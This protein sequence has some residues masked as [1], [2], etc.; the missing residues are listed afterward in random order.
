MPVLVLG[1][2]GEGRRALH[3]GEVVVARHR[4]QVERLIEVADL[5]VRERLQRRGA[6]VA[7]PDLHV[8]G[9]A[10]R[11]RPV[12]L[13]GEVEFQL[14]EHVVINRA[15]QLDA[16]AAQLVAVGLV[17]Q[18]AGH[19]RRLV[20]LDVGAGVEPLGIVLE[21]AADVKR[22]R[23]VGRL[24]LQAVAPVDA[25]V[26]RP[27]RPR[28]ALDRLAQRVVL[29]GLLVLKLRHPLLQR[30]QFRFGVVIRAR[31]RARQRQARHERCDPQRHSR[32]HNAFLH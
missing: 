12:V 28:D 26:R 30:V 11:A 22:E 7:A 24:E 17:P 15:V 2:K 8:V 29:G 20:L 1:R 19:G 23:L 13:V 18:R 31:R 5:H 21:P 9:R 25:E 14:V 16:H 32:S 27:G 3:E 10:A 4:F 6:D